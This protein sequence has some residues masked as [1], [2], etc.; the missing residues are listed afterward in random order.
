MQPFES[1][2]RVSMVAPGDRLQVVDVVQLCPDSL[3]FVVGCA[4]WFF[5]LQV[6]A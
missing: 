5:G 1:S 6:R 3:E 2:P 4:G